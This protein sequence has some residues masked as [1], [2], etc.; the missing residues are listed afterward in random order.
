VANLAKETIKGKNSTHIIIGIHEYLI[1]Q[2][3]AFE[4]PLN[5]THFV[6]KLDSMVL[7]LE[8]THKNDFWKLER[9]V[10]ISGLWKTHASFCF[11]KHHKVIILSGIALHFASINK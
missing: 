9:R 8:N 3:K 1:M 2:V 11:F 4:R 7:G 5:Y 6:S 10:K